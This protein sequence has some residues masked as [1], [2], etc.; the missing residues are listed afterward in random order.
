MSINGG[1]GASSYTPGNSG[2]STGE[3][4]SFPVTSGFYV[5]NPGSYGVGGNPGS[6]PVNYDS[7]G[8]NPGNPGSSGGKGALFIWENTA[9]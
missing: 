5:G 3:T 8:G 2:S 7:G 4:F 6:D 1:N 9:T